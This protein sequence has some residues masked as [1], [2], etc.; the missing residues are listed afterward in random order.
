MTMPSPPH[1]SATARSPLLRYRPL[2]LVLA[3]AVALNAWGSRWG[4][5]NR[6]HGDEVS[7]AAESLV[8]ERTINPHYFMY[9]GIGYYRTAL[10]VAPAVAYARLFDPPPAAG[11]DAVA[12]EAWRERYER[13]VVGWSRAVSLVEGVLLVLVAYVIGALLFDRRTGALGAALLALSPVIVY[14][15]HVATVDGVANLAQWLACLAALL[16]WRRGGDRWLALSV[17][18]AGV[19]TGAKTDHALVVIPVALAYAW[20]ERRT[21]RHL[22]LLLL[23][24]AGYLLANPVLLLQPFEFLDG[25]TRDMFFAAVQEVGGE[26]SYGIL[27]DYVRAGAGWPTF[28]LGLAGIA[29]AAVW[30][31]RGTHRREL[32]WLLSTVLPYYLIFGARTVYPW[33]VA[34]LLPGLSLVAAYAWM[35]AADRVP[36]PFAPVAQGALAALLLLALAGPVSLNLQFTH[37]PRF[38]AARWIER[39]VP[40]GAT[41]LVS[42]R[43]PTISG[44]RYRVE[45]MLGDRARWKENVIEPR[46]SLERHATYQRIRGTILQAERRVGIR[47]APYRG[48][49]DVV[50]D[51]LGTR[52]SAPE[53]LRQVRPDYVVIVEGMSPTVLDELRQPGS[54]YVPAAEFTYRSPL[55]PDL[56]MP[57]LN[58][59]VWVFRRSDAA[60]GRR[61]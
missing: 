44:T 23:L 29:A 13:R 21:W 40:P 4:V 57:M 12:R 33:Y 20:R 48:W 37:D 56:R 59:R 34:Q 41:I 10:G 7:W 31:A 50:L 9:G 54:G 2:W 18:L 6:W 8:R 46:D 51:E 19:A 3:L 52:A 24:P 5:L 16:S 25:L 42:G 17:L 36:R 1:P 30:I 22:P 11:A 14:I 61:A 49:Y 35:R 28:A 27:L 38:A 32:A 43:G 45:T 53:R 47:R 15:A 58:A 55:R 60:T 26:T 39:H